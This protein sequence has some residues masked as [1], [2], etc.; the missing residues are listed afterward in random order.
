MQLPSMRATAPCRMNMVENTEI[1]RIRQVSEELT[2]AATKDKTA[3]MLAVKR[4]T[5]LMT[6]PYVSSVSRF[7]MT[8]REP[9]ASRSYV[10]I[11][12]NSSR[13]K[14]THTVMGNDISHLQDRAT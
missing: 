11:E 13:M 14:T 6:S 3:K 2:N 4:T 9:Q 7:N 12:L 1:I 5:L 8:T 10:E